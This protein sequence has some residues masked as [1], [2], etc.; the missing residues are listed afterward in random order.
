MKKQKISKLIIDCA[1]LQTDEGGVM[2]IFHTRSFYFRLM[3]FIKGKMLVRL[4]NVDA[5]LLKEQPKYN[6]KKYG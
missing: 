4:K 2:G 5:L 6:E 3:F 1:K